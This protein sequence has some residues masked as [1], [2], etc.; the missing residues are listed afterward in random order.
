MKS[1]LI[2]R[3]ILRQFTGSDGKLVVHNKMT[4]MAEPKL[5]TDVAFV[6]IDEG[7]IRMLEDKWNHDVEN[8]AV[9]SLHVLFNGDALLSGKHTNMLKKIMA[10]HYVRSVILIYLLQHSTQVYQKQI[11]DEMSADSPKHKDLIESTVKERFP[12][13]VSETMPIILEENIE[14]VE[15]F[16]ELHGLEIGVAPVEEYF[17]LSDS[18]AMTMSNDGRMGVLNGVAITDADS[19]A[20]VV[21]PKHLVTLKTSPSKT[22]YI[23]LTAEQ[24]ANVNTKQVQHSLYEYYSVPEAQKK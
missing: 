11:I 10:L 18:P 22:K 13:M 14:K 21:S 23:Q 16:M 15:H 1:H 9:K 3:V 8:N 4:G 5:T 17:V 19:F 24:V 12:K 7:I 2:S 6:E 20:M